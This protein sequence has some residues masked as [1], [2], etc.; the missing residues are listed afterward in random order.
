MLRVKTPSVRPKVGAYMLSA[1]LSD[2]V[3]LSTWRFW[4]AYTLPNSQEALLRTRD[5]AY[6]PSAKSAGIVTFTPSV[7]TVVSNVL[8]PTTILSPWAKPIPVRVTSSP[9]PISPGND[10]VEIGL[11]AARRVMLPN[12]QLSLP[13]F[14]TTFTLPSVMV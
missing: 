12:V 3:M 9:I 13:V 5:T 1:A 14:N 8:S 4:K 10:K 6:S 11:S 2:T 7:V